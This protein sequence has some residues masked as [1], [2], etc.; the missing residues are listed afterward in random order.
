MFS[1]LRSIIAKPKAKEV[2]DWNIKVFTSTVRMD[3]DGVDIGSD[4]HLSIGGK[5]KCARCGRFTSS[6][7]DHSCPTLRSI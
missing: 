5:R 2:E 7:S 1:W 6:K 4:N 3:K